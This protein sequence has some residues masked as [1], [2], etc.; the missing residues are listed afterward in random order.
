MHQLALRR[1]LSAEFVHFWGDDELAIGLGGIV[2]KILLVVVFG[3]VEGG[4][5][6]DQTCGVARVR[7]HGGG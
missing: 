6:R 4:G 1:E 3:L 5:G 7:G 2:L